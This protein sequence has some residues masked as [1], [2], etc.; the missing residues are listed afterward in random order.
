MRINSLGFNIDN[1]CLDNFRSRLW[2]WWLLSYGEDTRPDQSN[3]DFN[4]LL[5]LLK[6]THSSCRGSS[7][8]TESKVQ[9]N[10]AH[11]LVNLRS[12]IF[13]TS[14]WWI[15]AYRYQ[16]GSISYPSNNLLYHSPLDPQRKLR[17]TLNN[18]IAIMG[19]VGRSQSVNQLENFHH[20]DYL[21]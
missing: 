11:L 8:N 4:S 5:R 7:S 19:R 2:K 15:V 1:Y 10:F 3:L 20:D 21:I 9:I 18:M 16:F 6:T 14:T 13:I 17:S 12:S